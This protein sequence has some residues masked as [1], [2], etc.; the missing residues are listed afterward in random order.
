MNLTALLRLFRIL[1]VFTRYRLDEL[2]LQL[3][4]P[5]LARLIL[6]VGPWRLRPA[7][8]ELSRGARLRRACEDLGPVF[9]KFGQI[10]STRRDLM[11][12]DIALE[13]ARLQD[14][15]PPF[16]SDLARKRIEEQL[17]QS[18]EDVFASFSNEPL[19]SA[20]VA[21]VH[22]ARLKDGT[23]VVVKVTRPGIGQTIHQDMQWLFLAARTLERFSS[24]ARRLRPLEVVGDYEKTIFD[25][26]DL[27]REAANASQLRRNFE[28][29]PLLYIPKIYWDWCRHKVLVMERIS[30][31]PVTD[32]EA[33]Y[34]Q[35]TDMKKLAEAGVELFFTQVFRDSFFHADMHPGNIFVSRNHPWQPQYIAV[36]F[37]I[38]GSLNAED[39]DYL[40]RNLLA[41]FKRD[42]RRVAQLH[43]D[44]GW[45]PADTRINEF[46]AAIR[47]VCEP[48]FER[49][50]KDISFGQLLLRL[51]Q[52]A[53][54]FNM[55]I[56]PQLVLLQKTLLNIEG[57]G[58]Q[59]YP[60]LD[61]WST[62]QP[63]LERWMRERLMPQQQL[64]NWQH[65]LEQVP[66][67][68]H[69]TQR[70]M[71]RL[72][73]PEEQPQ[74]PRKTDRALRVAGLV[75]AVLGAS[76]LGTDMALWH[77]TEPMQWILIA[78]G[79]WLVVRKS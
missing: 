25:E 37:G 58:R 48:I 56:Q 45:I 3:P 42:Y 2:V 50:L 39:Q 19:A 66:A 62:A 10:L 75:L 11:P 73:Q 43:I 72:A 79:G 65:Q 8:K 20:S 71:D 1:R 44:S 54:R 6:R 26:L 35:R 7:P 31:V 51:F 18:I 9:I 61:L 76:G 23:D 52:T 30:G 12:D 29:S 14:R 59:L 15:V 69:S 33:L 77:E 4:S 46:E 16:P 27:Y 60:D 36:D 13:L 47:S 17:G 38:V 78:A 28:G 24:E 49:P 34:D 40:A 22:A 41:F 5:W 64:R 70:A 68:L 63:Y 21:Q 67:L 53:R 32:L 57:L 55:E 74:P